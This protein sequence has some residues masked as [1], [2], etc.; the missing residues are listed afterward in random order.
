L[1]GGR[2]SALRVI[3][4]DGGPSLLEDHEQLL[5][6]LVEETHEQSTRLIAEVTESVDRVV[7]RMQGK[8][9]QY[10][11]STCCPDDGSQPPSSTH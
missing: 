5:D 8:L 9:D 1:Q 2:R 3:A 11:T 6:H 7:D 4:A 10:A